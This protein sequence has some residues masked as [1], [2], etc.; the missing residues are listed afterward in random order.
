LDG[1]DDYYLVKGYQSDLRD[2]LN[3][4]SQAWESRDV[5]KFM[6]RVSQDDNVAVYIKD[7]YAYSLSWQ[8]YHDMTRDAMK[9]IKT[10]SFDIYSTKQRDNG[11][12]VAYAKHV[13]TD[14]EGK[15][16]SVY[17]SYTLHK[18]NGE[19]FI[20]EAGASSDRYN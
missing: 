20:T 8:D 10:R 2:T 12:V 15:E 5:E 11:D 3:D 7:E 19:W 16:K 17:V 14:R 18:S 4:I 13:Y 6:D 1:A 9:S